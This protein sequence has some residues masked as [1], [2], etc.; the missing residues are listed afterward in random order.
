MVLSFDSV[1]ICSIAFLAG[2]VDAIA[3]GGGLIQIPGLFFLFPQ[4]PVV[5]LLGTNKLASFSGTLMA[6]FHY[7]KAMKI[8]ARKVYP[9]M[10]ASFL[11]SL[12]GAFLVTRM[13]NQQLKP[14]IFVLLIVIAIY[15][16]L[17]KDFG[18]HRK[19]R[20]SE[21]QCQYLAILIAAMM[22]FYDG[23]LGPGTG[24]ILIFVFVSCLGF[25]FLMGS[26][27][28][29]LCN[30]SSNLA[31]LIFFMTTGH[32]LYLM[33]LLMAAF[34]VFGNLLGAKL[35]ISKGS[36]FVRY[37]FLLVILG[38]LIQMMFHYWEHHSF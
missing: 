11:C 24:S 33:G 34:N 2:F 15:A 37:I 8:P 4:V 18:H 20:F 21:R 6:S 12:G 31:A 36:R 23:F 3:G 16:F 38:I 10:L 30:L 22:G 27:Y 28:A 25:D 29:K 17:K 1:S 32:V 14:I 19:I 35:A 5:N 26:A 7:L 9:M 13:H